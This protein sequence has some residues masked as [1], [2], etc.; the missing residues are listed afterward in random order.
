M[1]YETLSKIYYKNPIG[2]EQSYIARF[3]APSTRRFD[4][5]IQQY[6]HRREYQAFFCYTEEFALLVEK[7]CERR[8]Q[9]EKNL[10]GVPEIVLRQFMM[11][12]AIDEVKATNNIEGIASTRRELREA[13]ESVSGKPR[14]SSIMKKYTALLTQEKIAFETS[15]DV[16]R[17]YD[18][19]AHEEVI[20]EEAKSK[21]DGELFRK[22]PVEIMK[23][24]H[25]L[26][27]TYKVLESQ[28]SI[29]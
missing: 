18:E 26:L 8:A 14:F 6:N 29:I 3:N 4:F 16:R 17:F 27:I 19:F 15:A 11:S 1:G 5:Q 12:S 20:R 28:N 10:R 23:T 21:L 24:V 25:Y 7:I 22:E 2:H 13:L 9:L